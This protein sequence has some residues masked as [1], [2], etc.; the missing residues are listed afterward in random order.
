MWF[1]KIFK[2]LIESGEHSE[3]L[4]EVL[5]WC[6]LGRPLK[7]VF[8]L[9]CTFGGT[10]L[11]M[12]SHLP[13]Y[14]VGLVAL[15]FFALAGVGANIWER[16]WNRRKEMDGSSPKMDTPLAII[17]DPTNP[18]NRFWSIENMKDENGNQIAGTFWQYRAVIKNKS[19]RTVKNVKVTVEAIGAMP[20]RP[21]HSRFDINKKNFIDLTPSEEALAVIRTWFNPPL[22]QGMAIGEG[23]YGPIKMT[24]SAD[25]VLPTTTVFQFDPMQTPM[26]WI[27]D[28]NPSTH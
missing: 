9:A 11:A 21:V 7:T 18:R 23:A 5:E 19:V 10:I 26:I 3:F 25:D 2:R 1:R 4:W 17:F 20:T 14:G 13:A 24:A 28:V 27:I 22:V 8:L 16:W 6:G 15:S 12:I